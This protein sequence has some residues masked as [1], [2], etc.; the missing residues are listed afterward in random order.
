MVD[1]GLEILVGETVKKL[2]FENRSRT[3]QG[4][5]NNHASKTIHLLLLFIAFLVFDIFAYAFYYQFSPI[6]SW[7][8]G[9]GAFEKL[10]ETCTKQPAPISCQIDFIFRP[11]TNTSKHNTNKVPTVST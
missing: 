2:V 8:E 9:P 7:L 1:N 6:S 4:K 5:N 11:M 3:S 10:R